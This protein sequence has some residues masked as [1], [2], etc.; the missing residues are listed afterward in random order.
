MRLTTSG[1]AGL[2]RLA[3]GLLVWQDG[4]TGVVLAMH[5][6]HGRVTTITNISACC[7][8]P[9]A[10]FVANL[11]KMTSGNGDHVELVPVEN[12]DGDV[13]GGGRS[14]IVISDVKVLPSS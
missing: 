6:P 2:P 3:H 4:S 8:V 14:R 13:A 10:G 5:L 1:T 12:S 11:L 9:G 7:A